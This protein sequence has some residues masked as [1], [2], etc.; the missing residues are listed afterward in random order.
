[1]LVN[2]KKDA[3]APL[4]QNDQNNA[5]TWVLSCGTDNDRQ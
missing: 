5:I 4:E 3:I 2:L 1:M